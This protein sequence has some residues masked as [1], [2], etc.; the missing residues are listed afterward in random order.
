MTE[1]G[2]VDPRGEK[3]AGHTL[4][5]LFNADHGEPIPFV[6]PKKSDREFWELLLDTGKEETESSCYLPG[7]TVHLNACVVV[8]MRAIRAE[9]PGVANLERAAS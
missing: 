2:D 6:L 4:L 1:H 9:E 5:V 8:L 3:I 7:E